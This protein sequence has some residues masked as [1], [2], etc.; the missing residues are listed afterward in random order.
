MK[1]LKI[2]GWLT[3][4]ASLAHVAIIFGGADWYRFFGAGE[5]MA[6]MAENGSIYP[7]LLTSFIALM[8]AVWATFA[9]SGAGVIRS[10]PFTNIVLTIV[11]V[12]FLARGVFGVPLVLL[13]DD[14]YLSELSD[15]MMFMVI[16]SIFCTVLGTLYAYGV[17]KLK[18]SAAST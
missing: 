6:I 8:L 17:F 2:A 1:L 10:L 14:P 12:I 16:T 13:V 5:E 11:A 7:A 3:I 9:F 15:K 18:S 4:I